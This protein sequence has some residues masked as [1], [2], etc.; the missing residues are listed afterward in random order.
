MF[1]KI[2]CRNE[3]FMYKINNFKYE[4]KGLT[5]II[6]VNLFFRHIRV[7]LMIKILNNM[8]VIIDFN[9]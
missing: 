6:R 7:N 1:L 9:L 2:H 8:D 4:L 3:I 5:V